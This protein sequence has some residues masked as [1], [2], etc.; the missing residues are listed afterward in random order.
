MKAFLVFPHQLF[1]QITEQ[2]KDFIFYILEEP[3]YLDPS[4]FSVHKL[5]FHRASLKYMAD[6]LKKKGFAVDYLETKTTG[7]RSFLN[8]LLKANAVTEIHYYD[9]LNDRL[10][11]RIQDQ[12]AREIITV[13]HPSPLFHAGHQEKSYQSKIRSPERSYEDRPYEDMDSRE[14]KAI[15]FH[16]PEEAYGDQKQP[17]S[18]GSLPELW[19]PEKNVFV[20]EA[21]LYVASAFG[22]ALP[23]GAHFVHA[24]T[25]ADARKGLHNFLAHRFTDFGLYSRAMEPQHSCLFRSAIVPYLSAGLLTPDE[26]IRETRDFAKAAMIS[27]RC[28]EEL[29][30]Q[31]IRWKDLMRAMYLY[32]GRMESADISWD[33]ESALPEA[34]RKTTGE[35]MQE[36]CITKNK[37][38]P[39]HS[40]HVGLLTVMGNYMMLCGYDPDDV[41]LWLMERFSEI[42]DKLK[43]PLAAGPEACR[44]G[45]VRHE[46]ASLAGKEASSQMRVHHDM[47]KAVAFTDMHSGFFCAGSGEKI[48][49][50][51][52]NKPDGERAKKKPGY[53]NPVSVFS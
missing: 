46:G 18:S 21:I 47:G 24:V 48:L 26:V 43:I 20:Q 23:E 39:D 37:I 6:I 28:S 25:H 36:G 33:Q 32:T 22:V 10:E 14:H 52:F 16:E 50:A 49:P 42:T 31:V 35:I 11:K 12:V 53:R 1:R 7:D 5:I 4:R 9:P 8:G 30:K 3:E 41:C 45:G 44:D 51:T 2:D 15:L 40:D 17:V 38:I 27:R 13:K 34:F 19:V 29:L